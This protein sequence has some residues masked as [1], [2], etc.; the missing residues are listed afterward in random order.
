MRFLLGGA[1]L[2]FGGCALVTSRGTRLGFLLAGVFVFG[3]FRYQQSFLPPRV[4]DVSDRIGAAVRVSGLVQDVEERLAFRQA[5]VSDVVIASQ[6]VAGHVLVRFGLYPSVQPGDWVTFSCALEKPQPIEGFAYDRA[7]FA[8]G[9]L[10]VCSFPQFTDVKMSTDVP[11]QTHLLRWRDRLVARLKQI[12]PEPHGSF[13]AGLLFGGNAGLSKTMRD[14]FSRTGTSHVL[15]ASGYNVSIFSLMLLAWLLRSPLGRRTGLLTS[16]FILFG[17][18]LIA[19]ATASIIRA[20]LMGG[21]LILQMALR[22]KAQMLN[23][24]LLTLALMLL[25]NPLLLLNDVG[26]QL[27]FVATAALLFISPLWT[28]PLKMIPTTLGLREAAASSLTA[29]I[30]TLPI[31]LWHFGSLSLIAPVA[32]VL[33][34]PVV[35]FLM[36]LGA[37]VL[38]VSLLSPL[39]ASVVALPALALSFY[40]LSVVR[41]LGDLSFASISVTSAHL[42]AGVAGAGVLCWLFIHRHDLAHPPRHSS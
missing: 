18:V 21:L 8:R 11:I 36:A 7:L 10:A 41:V 39:L 12:V 27:S 19:G 3:L 31:T 33:I 28:E 14:D 29:I 23:I 24:F 35:P 9:I 20:G 6:S 38:A 30:F 22:R 16:S 1:A 40:A 34:L 15:A 13:V 2:I 5:T 42:I 17:Y 4:A 25:A 37:L 26:F 32:N